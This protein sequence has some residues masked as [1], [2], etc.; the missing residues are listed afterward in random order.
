MLGH[1]ADH[2]TLND[3]SE[4]RT[5]ILS[6]AIYIVC[7]LAA[8]CIV[9]PYAAPLQLSVRQTL[10]VLAIALSLIGIGFV[11]HNIRSGIRFNQEQTVR[12][13]LPAANKMGKPSLGEKFIW[14]MLVAA[15][16][17][18]EGIAISMIFALFLKKWAPVLFIEQP[19]WMLGFGTLVFSV[20]SVCFFLAQFNMRYRW[21]K[22]NFAGA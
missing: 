15:F 7:V 3:M 20:A 11:C 4:T 10:D 19:A 2:K 6:I 12:E 14:A 8:L 9:I 17:L 1:A 13:R 22:L 5:I 16:L 21:S 18:C